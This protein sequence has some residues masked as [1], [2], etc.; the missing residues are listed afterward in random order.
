[1]L[2][3][4]ALFYGDWERGFAEFGEALETSPDEEVRYAA[5]LGIA[6]TNFLSGELVEA[7][8]ILEEMKS[9]ESFVPLQDEV[10]F[11]LAQ[12]YQAQ[13]N[14]HAAADAY[15]RYLELRPGVIDSHVNELRGD[16]LFAAGD[17]QAAITAY[18]AALAAPLGFEPLSEGSGGASKSLPR[19]PGLFT[20]LLPGRAA[21][22][23]KPL[24]RR[25]EQG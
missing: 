13:E 3:D 25:H 8:A 5:R 14:Y 23:G 9:D 22:S 1:M 10:S 17:Y 4:Q 16:A 21:R 19:R 15:A 2:G 18:Q 6:R 7:Q 12:T 11:L 24:P 20:R